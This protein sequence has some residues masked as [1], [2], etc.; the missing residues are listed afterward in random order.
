M[1]AGKGGQKRE[2]H[3]QLIHERKNG[4]KGGENLQGP[5]SSWAHVQVLFGQR[6]PVLINHD[7]GDEAGGK[8]AR[9]GPKSQEWLDGDCGS[10][11]GNEQERERHQSREKREEMVPQA[12]RRQ[13]EAALEK[14]ENDH[15][16]L[17]RD[18]DYPSKAP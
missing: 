1:G 16:R 9:E 2:L 3:N 6:T 8:R 17:E 14:V 13:L 18:F 4:A 15:A 11:M 12:A 10:G 5:G 7:G